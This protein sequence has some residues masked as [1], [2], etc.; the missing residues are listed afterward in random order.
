MPY[1]IIAATQGTKRKEE[2]QCILEYRDH[3]HDRAEQDARRH[4]DTRT[5]E[6]AIPERRQ[7]E[8]T[9]VGAIHIRLHNVHETVNMQSK[10]RRKTN[11]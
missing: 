6:D 5:N 9:R 7:G 4:D 10:W 2:T 8:V 3:D 1:V 11:R